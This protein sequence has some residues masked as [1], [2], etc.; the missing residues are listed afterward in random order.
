MKIVAI[1]FFV[2]FSFSV[3]GQ[4]SAQNYF[5]EA[6]KKYVLNNTTAALDIVNEGLSKYP[7]DKKLNALK[8]KLEEKKEKDKDKDKN[9]KQDKKEDKKEKEDDK[10]KDKDEKGK[11]NPKNPN[12]NK[13][14]K[15]QDD[16][17]PKPK[18]GGIPQQRVENLL[19]AVNNQEKQVQEKVKVN[20][21][22]G[23]P[24]Q[25]EKDW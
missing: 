7:S 12:K 14:E 23:K 13:D 20:K 1:I 15:P 5:N 18:P 6:A 17:K 24:V 8:K 22:K 25:V 10:G 3:N 16:G 2:L 4:N 19:D 21:V 9:K 11:N